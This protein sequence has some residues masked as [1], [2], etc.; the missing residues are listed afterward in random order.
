MEKTDDQSPS[1]NGFFRSWGRIY[2]A[3]LLTALA[4]IVLL[5]W[6]SRVFA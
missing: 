3:V 1:P 2:A 6:F 5:F 4:V